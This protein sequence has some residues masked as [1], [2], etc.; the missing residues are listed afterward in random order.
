[1]VWALGDMVLSYAGSAMGESKEFI[2]RSIFFTKQ[3][4]VEERSLVK[5]FP[6]SQVRLS[7]YV[8]RLGSAGAVSCWKASL[9]RL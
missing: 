1:M 6:V 2:G 9:L 5:S 7:G 8:H 3:E 4:Q